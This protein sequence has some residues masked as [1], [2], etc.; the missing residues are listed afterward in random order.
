M[1]NT[2]LS[3][4]RTPQTS[5][6]VGDSE[7]QAGTQLCFPP[8][9][10]RPSPFPSH[11]RVSAR[12]RL[13]EATR[14]PLHGDS[15]EGPSRVLRPAE[16]RGRPGWP[17]PGGGA[18]GASLRGQSPPPVLAGVTRPVTA[19]Q[20]R[21][22]KGALESLDQARGQTPHPLQLAGP[23]LT[24]RALPEPGGAFRGLADGTSVGN[25]LCNKTTHK[26]KCR[27]KPLCLQGSGFYGV[28]WRSRDLSAHY[29]GGLG[30]EGGAPR[31]SW[32]QW[33]P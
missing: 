14:G 9:H 15:A 20:V 30:R 11:T 1:G 17:Q 13:F 22:G 26:V 8:R 29:P 6:Q 2:S 16:P 24:S 19:Q 25:L 32:G 21:V 3:P 4:G 12:S 31:A 28:S 33:V 5:L 7:P 27:L 23:A 18:H 10:K